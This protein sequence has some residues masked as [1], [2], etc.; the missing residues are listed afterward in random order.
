MVIE[1]IHDGGALAFWQVGSLREAKAAADAGCDVVVAQGLEA[2]GH[3]RGTTPLLDLL[4]QVVPAVKV[5]VLAT[6][7]IATGTQL[8]AALNTGAAGAR[9]GTRFLASVESGAHPDYVTALLEATADDTIIT[10]AF[11]QGWPDA[12]HRVLRGAIDCAE[13]HPHHIVGKVS[14][15]DQHWDVVRWAAQPPNVFTTGAV[16]AMAMYAGKG[17]G[18]IKDVPSARAI[19]ERITQ[20]ALPELSQIIDSTPSNP[21]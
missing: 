1:R 19:V 6:G 10:T 13:A 20:E 16:G 4:A 12:P 11:S 15:Q 18:H 2:G 7:G 3:V 14:Y 9:I 21:V 8:A 5:P 17:V